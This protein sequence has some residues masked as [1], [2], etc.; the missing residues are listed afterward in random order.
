MNNNYKD[1]FLLA[2]E[3]GLENIQIIESTSIHKESRLINGNLESD[4]FGNNVKYNIQA[5]YNGGTITT[6]SNYLDERIIDILIEKGIYLK[7]KKIDII[8]DLSKNNTLDEIVNL[9]TKR[10][11][12]ENKK[13]NILLKDNDILKCIIYTKYSKIRIINDFGVDM[14]SSNLLN[15]VTLDFVIKR[16]G[17]VKKNIKSVLLD[18]NINYSEFVNDLIKETATSLNEYDIESKKYKVLFKNNCMNIILKKL[19]P[20]LNLE[21]IKNKTSFLENKLNQ[22][23]F[24]DKLTIVEAP[25]DKNMP[26]YRVFD[27]EGTSTYNKI[28]VENGKLV[29]YLCDNKTA[30]E[31]NI[32][33][34]GNSYGDVNTRNMYIKPLNHSYNELIERLDNGIIITTI[35]SNFKIDIKDSKA[36]FQAY[37]LLVENGEIVGGLKPFIITTSY[38][39][40][41]NNI[42]EIGND[43]LFDN[44][45]CASPSIIIND[46]DITI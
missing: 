43:L 42:E 10:F 17:K 14:S 4:E 8:S 29:T 19:V 45:V 34:T 44:V 33:S 11:I 30:K 20:F 12:N 31:N 36:S 1:F 24:S 35:F 5:D 27:D 25:L 7:N 21:K 16:D 38:F 32:S 18:D 40:L 23:I 46:V 37:G 13:L 3:R 41:F 15:D 39:D 2:H 26:G 28:I 22:K 6:S 9:D